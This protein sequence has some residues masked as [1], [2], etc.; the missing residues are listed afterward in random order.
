VASADNWF[1][2]CNFVNAPDGTLHVLDMYREV[3][4]HP[5]S[6]PENI[7][8]HL[9]LSSGRDRGRVYRLAPPGFKVPAPPRLGK[10]AA[11]ELVRQLENPNAWWRETAQRLLIRRGDKTA[12]PGLKKLATGSASPLARLHAVWALEGLGALG[13]AEVA[14]ALAHPE[15]GLREHGLRLAE[16]RLAR[17]PGLAAAVRKLADDLDTRV[18]FQA[19]LT[20]GYL[21]GDDIVPLLARIADRDAGD[22]WLYLAVV[23]SARDREL[24][25]FRV[26]TTREGFCS[27]AL[28][29]L[30]AGTIGVRKKPG[31]AE[32]ALRY[33]TVWPVPDSSQAAA[34]LGLGEGFART[35]RTLSSL[36]IDPQ[37]PAG[38]MLADR[39]A[40]AIRTAGDDA[41]P[42]A[43]RVR[44]AAL[45]AHA[46]FGAANRNVFRTLLDPRQPQELQLAAVRAARVAA[47]GDVPALLLAGWRGYSPAVRA[48][49][50]A[51][52]AGRP[53]WAAA[54]LDAVAAKTLSPADVGPA[55]RAALARHRD[56]KVRDR[57]AALLGGGPSAPRAEVIARYR[58]SARKPGDKARGLAVFKREC[59][60]CHYA[61]GVGT[62]IGPAIA[63]VGTRTPDALLAAILDPNREIDPRYVS[64]AART[65]DGRIIVGIITAETATAVTLRGSSGAA[66][67]VL[68][69][70]IDELKSLGTSL[71]PDGF[72]QRVTPG[73]MADL[74]AFLVSV[75]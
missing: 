44:A 8:Q 67:T 35:G 7:K 28:L 38:R 69:T 9:D 3:V 5:W 47:A 59:A 24:P 42:V 66:E 13:E 32:E 64:Y 57:A 10:A 33:C 74:I 40:E 71:M 49:V 73:E 53:A 43:R 36:N 62:S 26:L 19:A 12:I 52:L 25:L 31:E 58:P 48:E 54:L 30:L 11:G 20:L 4:E 1:R 46:P 22:P 72:E 15:A 55:A 61:D 70:Q 2:P 6:I 34:I 16:P 27:D 63:A 21:P 18:R 23:S 39:F 68:R 29:Q 17:S 45:L 50:L 60:A 37:S 75:K 41:A 14:A 65:D 56:P 51:A